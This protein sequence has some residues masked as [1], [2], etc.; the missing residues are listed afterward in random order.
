[1]NL[2]DALAYK[3]RRR[4]VKPGLYNPKRLLAKG[5]GAFAGQHATHFLQFHSAGK[6]ILK[7]MINFPRICLIFF[8]IV[9]TRVEM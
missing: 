4:N 6:N 2:A 3:E 8:T 9:E 7:Y 1:M 5:V